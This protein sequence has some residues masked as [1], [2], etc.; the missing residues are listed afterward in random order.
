MIESF[1]D[2]TGQEMKYKQCGKL[3]QEYNVE[4]MLKPPSRQRHLLK[5]VWDG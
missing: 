4:I 1:K 3:F 5:Q 2:E